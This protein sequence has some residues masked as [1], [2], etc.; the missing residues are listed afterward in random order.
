MLSFYL[1]SVCV[2]LSSSN[3]CLFSYWCRVSWLSQLVES[4]VS[5]RY[6]VWGFLSLSTS[7]AL[8][9][10]KNRGSEAKTYP[11]RVDSIPFNTAQ[12]IQT[13]TRG[14]RRDNRQEKRGEEKEKERHTSETIRSQSCESPYRIGRICCFFHH[15]TLRP[16][17]RDTDEHTRSETELT[18]RTGMVQY[19][20]ICQLFV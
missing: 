14:R 16:E 7:A 3:C 6:W 9:E 8:R 17:R 4:V 10:R 12:S 13:Q 18:H 20:Y 15:R 1:H 19:M 2:V 5:Y 11:S